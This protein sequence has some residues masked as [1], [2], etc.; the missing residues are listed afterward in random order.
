VKVPVLLVV[1]VTVP[2]GVTAPVP[3]E[4]ATLAVQLVGVLSST[5]VGVHETVVVVVRLVEVNVNEPL[6]PV[7]LVSPA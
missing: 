1:K 2:V 4:S 6:L 7:W 5:L 3:E